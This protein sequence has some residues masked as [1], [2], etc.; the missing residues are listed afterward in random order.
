MLITFT[1]K[2]INSDDLITKS[3]KKFCD[4]FCKNYEELSVCRQSGK[5][6]F[7]TKD[8]K[9]ADIYFSVTH[10]GDYIF[11]A[12]SEKE[13]G[14]DLQEHNKKD[15][16][17]IS[18]RLYGIVDMKE[19]EFYDK[20]TAGEAH[21]KAKGTGLI[22]GLME[23]SDAVNINLLINYSFAVESE[24]KSIYFLEI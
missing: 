9:K 20:F 1:A 6:Y 14:I 12:I 17:A 10:S 16:K 13:V 23:K 15:I 3:Y 18:T 21:V 22:E 2:K 11:C 19:T 7:L 4:I 24:D 5:P 8:N